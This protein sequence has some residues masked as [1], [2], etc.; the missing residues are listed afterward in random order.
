MFELS[1]DLK[2]TRPDLKEVLK[3]SQPNKEAVREPL[4]EWFD[5]ATKF[6]DIKSAEKFVTKVRKACGQFSKNQCSGN[7]CG[8]DSDTNQCKIQVRQSLDKTKMFNRLLTTL[9]TNAKLRGMVL[10]GRSTPFFSTILYIELP[11]ELILTDS[12]LQSLL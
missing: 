8:W 12:E 9:V 1:E 4:Q 11:H 7:V 2:E 5:N 6:V 3:P 10:D